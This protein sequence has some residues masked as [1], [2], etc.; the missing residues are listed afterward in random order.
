MSKKR[1]I[2]TN[3]VLKFFINVVDGGF[4]CKYIYENRQE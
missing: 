1:K 2:P 4:Q 3:D